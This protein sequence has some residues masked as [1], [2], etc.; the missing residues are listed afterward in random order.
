M[1]TKVCTKCGVEKPLSEFARRKNSEPSLKSAC[2]ECH[3][4]RARGYW[5]IKPL[6]KEVQRERNLRKSFGIGVE[7]YNKLLKAQGGSCAICGTYACASGRNFAV[8]HDHKTGKVRGLLC[9]F[10]NTALGQFQDSRDYL[11]NAIEYLERNA[12]GNSES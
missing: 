4:E 3:R 12:D 2:K 7:E 10:C 1:D 9:K 11:L 5:K 8:D 6:P